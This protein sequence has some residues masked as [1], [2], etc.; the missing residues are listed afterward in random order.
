M[1]ADMQRV[2]MQR[3]SSLNIRYAEI[4]TSTALTASMLFRR[5]TRKSSDCGNESN[6]PIIEKVAPIEN[7]YG[8]YADN[9]KIGLK[10]NPITAMMIIM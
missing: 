2:R 3:F 9:K 8:V 5:R 6:R 10:I 4:R 1:K 7:I